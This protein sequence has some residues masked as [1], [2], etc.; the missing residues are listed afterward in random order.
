MTV[1]APDTAL[2]QHVIQTLNAEFAADGI[3][4]VP[5]KLHPALGTTGP[6]GGVYPGERADMSSNQLVIELTC[7]VQLFLK[8]DKQID[9]AQS[10]D[11]APIEEAAERIARAL[12]ATEPNSNSAAGP[13][14][15]EAHVQRIQYPYD[16]TGNI[17]RLEATVF[18]RAQN[19]AL[20]ST[21]G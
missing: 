15:W 9:P 21:G 4:F 12:E 7:Y 2:R 6:V 10:V 3:E 20:V 14:L 1:T 19:S 17:T 5:D 18:G 13:H 8:W 11:P 16:P